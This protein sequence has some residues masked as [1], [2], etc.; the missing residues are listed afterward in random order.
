MKKRIQKKILQ[1]RKQ[2]VDAV[3]MILD[4]IDP[5]GLLYAASKAGFSL[6]Q[7]YEPEAK[8]LV[9]RLDDKMGPSDIEKELKRIFDR[10]FH[11]ADIPGA[12]YTAAARKS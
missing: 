5:M 10:W 2:L 4:E 12:F 11:F 1:K 9:A 6:E 8:D 3:V 7:K